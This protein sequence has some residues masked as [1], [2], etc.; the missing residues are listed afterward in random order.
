[1]LWEVLH[2]SDPKRSESQKAQRKMNRLKGKYRKMLGGKTE[3]G[4][5]VE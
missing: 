3:G 2:L 1:M 4:I 5:T